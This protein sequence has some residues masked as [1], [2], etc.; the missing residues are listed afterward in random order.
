MLI[1]KSG[2]SMR[3]V[4]TALATTILAFFSIA[5]WGDLLFRGVLIRGFVIALTSRGVS[6]VVATEC[7]VVISALLF[8]VLHVNA[9]VSGLSTAVVV[10]QT[11]VG[12]LYFGLAQVLTDSLALPIGIHFQ[13]TSG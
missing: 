9:G 4:V 6:R 13:R 3:P 12:G 7:A 2:V 8:G 1:W 10:L 11:V 5:V